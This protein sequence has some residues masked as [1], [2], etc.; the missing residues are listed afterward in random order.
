MRVVL[1][2]ITDKSNR[3]LITQRPLHISCAGFWEFPGGKVEEDESPELALIR[4]V[5]EEVGLQVL[6]YN[7]LNTWASSAT[8]FFIHHVMAFKGHAACCES[9]LD[10]RW[11]DFAS[12]PSYSFPPANQYIIPLI[13][14][15][16]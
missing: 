5:Q 1:A 4:E 2:I 16:L 11:V 10:L 14:G 12:L 13:E 8:L 3:I 9:Q 7:F 6:Q 15:C